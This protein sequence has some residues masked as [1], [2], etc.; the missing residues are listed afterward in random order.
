MTLKGKHIVAGITGSIAAYKA[1]VLV[2]LLVK[3]GAEVKVMMTALAKE[4]ITPLTMATLSRNPVLVDFFD[5]E[6]GAWNSHVDL[7]LWADA[8]LIAPATANTI[9]GMAAGTAGNL[10]LATY[11]AARCPVFV[12]PAMD[13]DM[14]RHTAT[15]QNIQTLQARGVHIIEPSTGALA[16]GLDG[17]GRMEEPEKIVRYVVDAMQPGDC[18]GKKVLVTAGPTYEPVDPVRFV[19]NRSSGRMGYALAE[20]LAQRGAEVILVSGP[21]ALSVKHPAIRR[22]DV[23]TAAEMYRAATE[24][25][26]AMDA[27]MMTAAVADFT[28]AAV[29]SEKI[30]DKQEFDLKLVPTKDIAAELGAAKR[31]GQ[32]LAG[33]A[34]ETHNE[35]ENAVKKLTKKNFN[36]IVLNSLNDAGAGFGHDTNKIT[37]IDKDRHSVHFELKSKDRVAKDIVDRLV[38]CWKQ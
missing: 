22:V 15:T 31:P 5:P 30:K 38:A 20:E 32:V 2:R 17:K 28:P 23:Q 9:A 10:L 12:A 19:G 26:P 18:A 4:F 36:F 14:F 35:T 25:F 24:H 8:L 21:T 11:L 27:A 29:Q 6:N 1:A 3:E 16:S 33:F 13:L 7:G 37:I 34:L